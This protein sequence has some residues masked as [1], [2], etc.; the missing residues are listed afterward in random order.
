MDATEIRPKVMAMEV[1][2]I[3]SQVGAFLRQ[4]DL[5]SCV[6]V[7]RLWYETYIPSLFAKAVP[8]QYESAWPSFRDKLCH[9][10]DLEINNTIASPMP[11][12]IKQHCRRLRRLELVRGPAGGHQLLDLLA[13]LF[14]QNPRLSRFNL[15][16]YNNVNP[17]ETEAIFRTLGENC[18]GLREVR[19]HSQILNDRTLNYVLDL[20]PKLR[21][22]EWIDNLTPVGSNWRTDWPEFPLL[23]ELEV[24]AVN[25]DFPSVGLLKRCKRTPGLESLSWSLTQFRRIPH[26]SISPF[27]N[28]LCDLLDSREMQWQWQW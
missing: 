21:R 24:Q 3:R 2:E 19:I 18:P 14:E 20:A 23:R 12:D 6:L 9:L 27:L 15:S 8:A 28:H 22:L 10:E 13:G 7:S 17:N 4:H 11:E 1:Y 5:A 25:W 26:Y 16:R